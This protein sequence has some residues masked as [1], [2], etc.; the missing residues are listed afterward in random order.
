MLLAVL[1]AGARPARADE[2]PLLV[3]RK[4]RFVPD[5]IEVPAQRE[6]PTAW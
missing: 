3:F 5:R 6:I 4:H 2:L 1:L